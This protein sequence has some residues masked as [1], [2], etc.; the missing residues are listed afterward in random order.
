MIEPPRQNQDRGGTTLRLVYLI[1]AMCF[2]LLSL[3]A[4]PAWWSDRGVTIPGATPSDYA[5]V[6][7][8]QLK[9][10]ARAARDELNTH[11][12]GGAGDTINSTW[13]ISGR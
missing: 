8:G 12:P 1:A 6:N 13:P 3:A 4:E 2:P 10:I 7:Q 9:N 5:A 11:L